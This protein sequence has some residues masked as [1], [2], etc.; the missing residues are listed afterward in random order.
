MNHRKKEAVQWGGGIA[1][2]PTEGQD[3]DNLR[4]AEPRA[5][6]C[7][8]KRRRFMGR[9]PLEDGPQVDSFG[10]SLLDGFAF[11]ILSASACARSLLVPGTCDLTPRQADASASAARCAWTGPNTPAP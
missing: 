3:P 7:A 4:A 11:P 10:R 1:F 5:M 6:Q 2:A 9:T 8:D